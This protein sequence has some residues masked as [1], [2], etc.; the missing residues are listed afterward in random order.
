MAA[1]PPPVMP[2]PSAG[3]TPAQPVSSSGMSSPSP[4]SRA[5][6]SH[7]WRVVGVSDGDTVTCLDENNQQQKI[8]LAGIDAPEIGQDYGKTS[9][10]ALAGMVFGRSVEVVDDGRDR[11]GRWIGHLSVDGMNVNRQLVATG[12]AWHYAA[13]SN[14]QDLAALQAQAQAQRIGLWSQPNPTSPWDYRASGK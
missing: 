8:R 2:V 12:N 5:A 13:Y 1:L 4:A 6:N 10:E 11:Y 9:R 14:D 3:S 7:L